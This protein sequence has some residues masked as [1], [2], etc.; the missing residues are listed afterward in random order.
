MYNICVYKI[1]GDQYHKHPLR[2]SIKEAKRRCENRNRKD[3]KYYGGK[4]I[5]FRVGKRK[6]SI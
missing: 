4:G 2:I 3:Y 1:R 6:T 5:E